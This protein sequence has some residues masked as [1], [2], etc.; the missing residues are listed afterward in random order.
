MV[1]SKMTE[2]N[3]YH[4][5]SLLAWLWVLLTLFSVG[6]KL[7]RIDE[8]LSWQVEH[9]DRAIKIYCDR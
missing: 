9:L 1:G 8:Q 6:L 4:L 2:S 5:W 7:D 3:L